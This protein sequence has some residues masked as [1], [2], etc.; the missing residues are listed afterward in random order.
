MSDILKYV[1]DTFGETAAYHV[2]NEINDEV[3]KLAFFP[4]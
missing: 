2:N 1:V 4:Q 3:E